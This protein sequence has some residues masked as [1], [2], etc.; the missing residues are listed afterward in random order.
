MRLLFLLFLA[1]VLVF[2]QQKYQLTG[3]VT[4]KGLTVIPGASVFIEGTPWAF[5]RMRKVIIA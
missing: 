5:R 2:A 4:E 1:P 3:S